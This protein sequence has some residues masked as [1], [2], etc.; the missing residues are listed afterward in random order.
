MVRK[1]K[2]YV[3][4][5]I[6]TLQ[7]FSAASGTYINWE[8]SSAYWFDRYIH[9][10]EWLGE[11][12]WQWAT[13]GELYKL[14][15]TS[16]GLNRNTQYVD[17]FLYGESNK[18]IRILESNEVINCWESAHMQPSFSLNFL[19][20]HYGIGRVQ[21]DYWKDKGSNPELFLVW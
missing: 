3:D 10:P 13:E 7:V 16:F 11:Y 9:K 15:C 14:L 5:M 17:Q 8:K 4:E 12:Q 18:K 21:Q 20:F 1:E 2:L 19:V 6:K